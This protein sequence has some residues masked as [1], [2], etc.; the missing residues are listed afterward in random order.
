MKV[1]Q[2][3]RKWWELSHIDIPHIEQRE[4]AFEAQ[5]PGNFVRHLSFE[6]I[7][8]LRDTLI[9]KC[10]ISL[11]HSVTR[12]LNNRIIRD[13]VFDVDVKADDWKTAIELALEE[14][15]ALDEVVEEELGLNCKKKFSGSKGFHVECVI[16]E[17]SPWAV[18]SRRG[19]GKLVA[20]LSALPTLQYSIRGRIVD[21][22]QMH[23][24]GSCRRAALRLRLQYIDTLVLTRE[25]GLIRSQWSINPKSGL[26]AVPLK[27]L[28][29]DVEDLVD[30]ASPVKEEYEVTLKEKVEIPW[31]RKLEPGR[32]KVSYHE[33]L[34]LL[35]QGLL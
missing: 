24:M 29:V 32:V 15:K 8:A 2:L 25:E 26:A 20:Y 9:R 35:F 13:V 14:L 21:I 11:Y 31:S 22:C 7:E 1:C 18:M 6:S 16:D 23:P 3:M 5:R 30:M 33:L 17:D 19:Y 34:Y 10:A 12:K 27:S 28:D 4:I